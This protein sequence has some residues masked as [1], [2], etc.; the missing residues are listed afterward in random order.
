M[1]TQKD[2]DNY[3]FFTQKQLDKEFINVC[4]KGNLDKIK[5]LLTSPDLKE[6]A[7][8][9]AQENEGLLYACMNEKTHLID[10]LVIE[11]NMNISKELKRDLLISNKEGYQY[12]LK[13]IETLQ[14][15][16]KMKGELDNKATY[17][18]RRKI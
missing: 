4:S 18:N 11:Y 13:L 3:S 17:K 8:I 9:H 5:Y 16:D 2:K 15:S 1:I 10:Y 12:A 6:H 7:D 14:L